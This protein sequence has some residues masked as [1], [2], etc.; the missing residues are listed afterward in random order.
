MYL[1]FD[2]A[3]NCHVVYV[4]FTFQHSFEEQKRG[5]SRK[6]WLQSI[7]YS[8]KTSGAMLG[9][10]FKTTF[11]VI[12]SDAEKHGMGKKTSSF[13]ALLEPNERRNASVK[14]DTVLRYVACTL[15]D[16]D[17][18][19]N[20]ILHRGMKCISFNAIDSGKPIHVTRVLNHDGVHL[21]NPIRREEVSYPAFLHHYLDQYRYTLFF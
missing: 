11:Q 10:V 8:S 13:V 17:L 7:D 15:G 3:I 2:F 20:R 1:R 12:A 19:L 6:R 16:T 18:I 4:V 5:E 9:P 14:G 21:W